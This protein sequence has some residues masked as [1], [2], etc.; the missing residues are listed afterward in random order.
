M[1]TYEPYEATVAIERS[2]RQILERVFR[3]SL[4]E[5]WYVELSNSTIQRRAGVARGAFEE[6]ADREGREASSASVLD[7]TRLQDLLVMARKRWDLLEPALGELSDIDP[8]LVRAANYRNDVM[9]GRP[10]PPPA[11]DI[12]S[13]VA[14]ELQNKIGA[15]MS[16]HGPTG[17]YFPSITAASDSYGR[18][19]TSAALA[20]TR[21]G[22]IYI[23]SGDP[24]IVHLGDAVEVEVTAVDPEDRDLEWIS[25]KNLSYDFNWELRQGGGCRRVR[26][27]EPVRFTHTFTRVRS[28]AS[29]SI[30]GRAV[31]AEYHQHD[32]GG[33][34]VAAMFMF[35]VLPPRRP[36]V[37][38]PPVEHA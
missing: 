35:Q 33:S 25:S 16:D 1:T 17:D 5:G 32:E 38:G 10:L 12:L 15:Y 34:D 11:R 22:L 8:L 18:V 4:G 28:S 27:G 23:G 7:F 2:L 14:V 13:G 21:N 31:G 30:I 19:A 6:L 3:E 36:A 37:S 9:H 29:L 26:S 20:A 24:K